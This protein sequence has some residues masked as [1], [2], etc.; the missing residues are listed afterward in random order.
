MFAIARCPARRMMK[1]TRSI[2]WLR[3]CI[4]LLFLSPQL[5]FATALGP[6]TSVD[7]LQRD[8][9]EPHSGASLVAAWR[10]AEGQWTLPVN[11]SRT[12]V[13]FGGTAGSP[14]VAG[15]ASLDVTADM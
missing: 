2:L 4:T 7:T 14:R 10:S 15:A 13:V 11:A 5:A 1:S 12:P 6:G 3:C 9:D 8:S